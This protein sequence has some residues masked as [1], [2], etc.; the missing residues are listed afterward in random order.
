MLKWVGAHSATHADKDPRKDDGKLF[1][2]PPG[3]RNWCTRRVK[4]RCLTQVSIKRQG[5]KDLRNQGTCT[6]CKPGYAFVM[7]FHKSR[8]GECSPYERVSKVYTAPLDT[9]GHA[10]PQAKNTVS[11]KVMLSRNTLNIFRLK[12]EAREHFKKARGLNNAGVA[13]CLFRKETVCRTRKEKRE[14]KLKDVTHCQVRKQVKCFQVCKLNKYEDKIWRKGNHVIVA[15]PTNVAAF[16]RRGYKPL[17][18]GMSTMCKAWS[19]SL[20]NSRYGALACTDAARSE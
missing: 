4:T 19:K 18:L 9:D 1:C 6:S 3:D 20:C 17:N 5:K 12:G 10:G 13:E 11:T 2:R 15:R 14:G 8:A 16:A 7:K